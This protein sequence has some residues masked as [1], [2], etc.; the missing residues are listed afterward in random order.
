MEFESRP[1]VCWRA[2]AYRLH[3]S[4][5]AVGYSGFL[6]VYLL[7]LLLVAFHDHKEQLRQ[8][9]FCAASFIFFSWNLTTALFFQ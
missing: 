8:S 1:Q 9:V 7:L 6:I 3:G 5:P 2:F 4:F